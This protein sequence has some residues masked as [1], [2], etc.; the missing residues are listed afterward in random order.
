MAKSDAVR[1]IAQDAGISQKAANATYDTIVNYVVRLCKRGEDVVLPGLGTFSVT[2][3]RARDGRNPRTAAV[4]TAAQKDSVVS[5]R[6]QGG[7]AQHH[8]DPLRLFV[9][10][11]K[12]L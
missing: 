11:Y 5:F 1:A 9:D 3:R 7:R 8:V 2:S 4:I 6:A 10:A 12:K